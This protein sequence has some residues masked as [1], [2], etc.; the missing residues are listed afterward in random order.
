LLSCNGPIKN[1]DQA[2]YTINLDPTSDHKIVINISEN[3]SGSGATG[4]GVI[5]TLKFKLVSEGT[6]SVSFSNNHLYNP[7]GQE[8]TP[9]GW[10]GSNVIISKSMCL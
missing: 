6:S 2:S 3:V 1:G 4:N 8:I 10:T 5:T 7:N 9:D